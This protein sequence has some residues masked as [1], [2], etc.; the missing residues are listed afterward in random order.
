M[1]RR[2]RRHD[3]AEST[4]TPFISIDKMQITTASFLFFFERKSELYLDNRVITETFLDTPRD[5][6]TVDLAK[7]LLTRTSKNVS[8][9]IQLTFNMGKRTN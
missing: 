3:D 7:R 9:Y 8:W 5:Y 4:I 6:T 2:E 1:C